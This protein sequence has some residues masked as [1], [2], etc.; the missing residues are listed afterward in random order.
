VEGIKTVEGAQ[1]EVWSVS[2]GASRVRVD[3]KPQI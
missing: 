1:G 2:D 3:I